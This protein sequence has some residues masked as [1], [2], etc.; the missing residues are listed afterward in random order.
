MSYIK[1]HSVEL[2][3]VA[4]CD[5][6]LIHLSSIYMLIWIGLW[7][8]DERELLILETEVVAGQGYWERYWQLGG[9]GLYWSWYGRGNIPTPNVFP[10]GNICRSHFQLRRSYSNMWCC[11]GHFRRIHGLSE[12]STGSGLSWLADVYC[13]TDM[14]PISWHCICIIL[15]L[16]RYEIVRGILSCLF[17]PVYSGYMLLVGYVSLKW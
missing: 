2:Y 7:K 4:S 3:V 1:C 16:I 9:R 10:V 6:Y 5:S 8:W 12:T 13:R 11:Q 14:H 17:M 15:H